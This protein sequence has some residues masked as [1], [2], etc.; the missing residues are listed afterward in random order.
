MRK[1]SFKEYDEKRKSAK[2]DLLEI[3][4]D[5]DKKVSS[6]LRTRDN[7]KKFFLYKLAKEKKESML[8]KIGDRRYKYL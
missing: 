2:I 4:D 7:E 8:K 1:I 3:G 5:L 6:G